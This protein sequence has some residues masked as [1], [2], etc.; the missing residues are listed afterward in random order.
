MGAQGIV[1][2]VDTTNIH[3]CAV[4]LT[5]SG[6]IAWSSNA[7]NNPTSHTFNHWRDAIR[8]F[9]G[10]GNTQ[11]I[12]NQGT[13]AT[14]PAAWSTVNIGQSWYLPSAGQL[15]LLFGELI[16]VNTSFGLVGGVPINPG[17]DIFLWSSTEK[18]NSQAIVIGISDGWVG[19][20]DKNEDEDL[21]VRAVI[22]F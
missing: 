3:G 5:Q 2:Y 16:T 18:S 15:N 12:T 14:Y 1:F 20:Y 10:D 7:N 17:D 21:Y 4:S 19:G 13:A 8:D 9:D 22:D 6:P 11:S